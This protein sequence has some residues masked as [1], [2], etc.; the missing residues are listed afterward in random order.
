VI[1]Q[2]AVALHQQ[3]AAANESLYGTGAGKIWIA[4]LSSVGQY[5]AACVKDRRERSL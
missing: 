5:L 3:N 1:D 4:R 2:I